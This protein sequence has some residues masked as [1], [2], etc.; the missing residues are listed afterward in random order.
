M[1]NFFSTNWTSFFTILHFS[2]QEHTHTHTPELISRISSAPLLFL[3]AFPAE[4]QEVS[5][6]CSIKDSTGKKKVICLRIFGFILSQPRV[7]WTNSPVMQIPWK[8]QCTLLATKKGFATCYVPLFLKAGFSVA[9]TEGKILFHPKNSSN[10]YPATA[11]NTTIVSLS[12]PHDFSQ[13]KEACFVAGLFSE[14][15]VFISG[16][17]LTLKMIT[18]VA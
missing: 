4:H 15:F 10:C 1:R 6:E 14:I 2:L 16:C 13:L 3:K 11:Q 9:L 8:S 12:K 18:E 17:I 7:L 5:E